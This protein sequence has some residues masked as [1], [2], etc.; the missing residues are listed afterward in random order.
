[1]IFAQVILAQVTV[2]QVTTMGRTAGA[3]LAKRR[4]P[5][6]DRPAP[7]RAQA[8]R[9]PGPAAPKS[10]PCPTQISKGCPGTETLQRRPDA[11]AD[12]QREV[13]LERFRSPPA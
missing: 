5:R 8:M 9:A 6:L 2:A 7:P 4:R 3:A 10:T 11:S 1:M 13:S 12:Q